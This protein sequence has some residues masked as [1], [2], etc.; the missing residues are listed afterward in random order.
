ML[1]TEWFDS[2]C[3]QLLIKKQNSLRSYRSQSTSDNWSKYQFLRNQMSQLIRSKQPDHSKNCFSLLSTIQQKW[4]YIN[5][6]RGTCS[7]N[8]R[9]T[10]LRNS[11]SEMITQ[12]KKISNHLNY[13]FSNLGDFFGAKKLPNYN[14]SAFE[15]AP[16]HFQHI[17]VKQCFDIVR[18]IN[19]RKPLGPCTVPAWAIVDGQ[20]VI[21]PHLTFVINTCLDENNFPI[22]LKKAEKSTRNPF[23]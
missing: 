22:E 10:V 8:N 23:V 11:F 14:K 4:K 6:V 21:V 9:I 15:S 13:I 12:D 5:Q 16:F 3:Q 18:K 7:G 20:S 17:T 2:E 1:K 19:V